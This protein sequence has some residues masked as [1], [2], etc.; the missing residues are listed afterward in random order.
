MTRFVHPQ[1]G[2]W[3]FKF[4]CAARGVSLAVRSQRNFAIHLPTTGAV[5]VAAAALGA[6]LLEWA[7]LIL[8]VAVVLSAEMFN[9]AIEH[10]VGAIAREQNPEVRDA[11]DVSS[12]AVL[13][14]SLG[15]A[16]IGGLIFLHLL[17]FTL[18]RWTG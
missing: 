17:S 2:N 11:L 10:L 15:A 16:L 5:I 8:C 12:G 18:A 9:T 6:S 4:R 7:L 3:P 1:H 14:I 13:L